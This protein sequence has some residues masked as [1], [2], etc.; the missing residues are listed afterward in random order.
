MRRH[1]GKAKGP[2]ALALAALGACTSAFDGR[3]DDE[4]FC[5][6]RPDDPVC[7]AF[8]AGAAGAAGANA[9]AGSGIGGRSGTAG[10]AGSGG[11]S[12]AGSAGSAGGAGG[13]G[14]CASDAA[15]AVEVGPGSLCLGGA[16]TKTTGCDATTLVVVDQAFVGPIDAALAN[17]CSFRQLA[18]ADAAIVL[19]VTRALVV[20]AAAL[21][22]DAPFRLRRGVALEGRGAGG[23][24]VA[25]DFAASSEG[26]LLTLEDGSSAT[27]FALEG[28]ATAIGVVAADGVASLRGPLTIAHARVALEPSVGATLEARGTQAAPVRLFENAVGARV[29]GSAA[30]TLEGDG[31]AAGFVIEGTSGGAGVLV[32]NGDA[33]APVRL[34]GLLARHNLGSSAEGSGAIEV[35][36]GRTVAIVDGVF[37]GNVRALS[38]NGE[39]TSVFDSFVGVKI[40]RNVFTNRPS[41]S[42]LLCGTDLDASASLTIGPDNRFDGTPLLSQAACQQIETSQRSSC[43]LGGPLGYT[44]TGKPFDLQCNALP[45]DLPPRAPSRRSSELL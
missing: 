34:A 17:A 4:S 43:E 12:G 22:L 30:L 13:A 31:A 9:I 16:C 39:G 14:P 45:V 5:R 7:G 1:V 26:A 42:V 21:R 36:R 10:R 32:L 2:I 37:E 29:P 33:S 38:F 20:Y 3:V 6:T 15:C 40:E 19:D 27:G 11:A 8:A 28:H 18:T 44:A 35:R 41:A 24:L 25:L 23:A